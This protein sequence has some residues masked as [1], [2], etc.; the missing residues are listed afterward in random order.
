MLKEMLVASI[1]GVT[2]VST[3][4]AAN[5]D[6]PVRMTANEM[7]FAPFNPQ[8]PE[9]PKV[10]HLWGNPKKSANAAM[11]RFPAGFSSDLRSNSSSH[12]GVVI[13]GTFINKQKGEEHPKKLTAGSYWFEPGDREYSMHCEGA[14]ECLV[15]MVFDGP[16][17]AK[18]SN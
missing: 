4:V 12:R 17:D 6:G 16:Y 7:A 9:G 1:V 13:Q 2:C 8:K 5:A 3:G 18:K 11:V 10:V 14:E 15:Y